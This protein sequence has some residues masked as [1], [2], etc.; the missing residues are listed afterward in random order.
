MPARA[1]SIRRSPMNHQTDTAN[2][3]ETTRKATGRVKEGGTRVHDLSDATNC[4]MSANL[5][6]LDAPSTSIGTATRVAPTDVANLLRVLGFIS[7]RIS[8]DGEGIAVCRGTCAR[9]VAW[10]TGICHRVAVLLAPPAHREVAARA[11]DEHGS[12]VVLSRAAAGHIGNVDVRT[13]TDVVPTRIA[14]THSRAVGLG[15][16]GDNAAR[17]SRINVADRQRGKCRCS[18]ESR[19]KEHY[20]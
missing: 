17:E 14:T 1:H 3:H 13:R 20:R 18:K 19:R 10:N 12:E 5:A 4:G 11:R 9:V 2:S 7:A 16:D 6:T 8:S 15:A